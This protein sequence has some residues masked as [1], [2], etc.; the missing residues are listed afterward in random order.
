MHI[1]Y[2]LKTTILIATYNYGRYI[3]N[4]FMF[5]INFTIFDHITCNSEG[6]KQFLLVML[7]YLYYFNYDIEYKFNNL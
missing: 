6:K 4:I 7:Y 3:N 2:L 5:Q 1:F